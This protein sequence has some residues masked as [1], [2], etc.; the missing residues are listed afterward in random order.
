[1]VEFHLTGEALWARMN[2]AVEKIQERLEKTTRTMEAVGFAH[3]K[4]SGIDMFLDVELIDASWLDR[5]P[6]ELGRRLQ[7]LLDNP[8]S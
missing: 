8:E 5:F 1:M 7:E 2:R 4:S 6:P 3:R